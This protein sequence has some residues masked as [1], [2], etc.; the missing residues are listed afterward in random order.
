M[1]RTLPYARYIYGETVTQ[2]P[3]DVKNALSIAKLVSSG[4][5]S[6]DVVNTAYSKAMDFSIPVVA[7][8]WEEMIYV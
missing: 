2:D 6:E 1:S 5:W 4:D 3:Y 8:K 7:K